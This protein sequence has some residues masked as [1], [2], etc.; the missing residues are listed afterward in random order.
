M[1]GNTM[2]IAA[3]VSTS[4][5]SEAA[6]LVRLILEDENDLSGFQRL[7]GQVQKA[8]MPQALACLSARLLRD[9]AHA[10]D[11]EPGACSPRS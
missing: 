5:W 10:T 2:T 9:L 3:E 1:P 4:A 8:W 11:S 6:M 7:E